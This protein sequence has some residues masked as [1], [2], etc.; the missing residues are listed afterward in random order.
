M[1]STWRRRPS[2]PRTGCV[3]TFTIREGA[4]YAS[5][6]PVLADHFIASW[7]R[8]LDPE[9]LSPMAAFMQPLKGFD[10]WLA[11][12][13]EAAL[14]FRAED[15]RNVVVELAA[16]STIF[17]SF[18]ASFVWAVID[19]AVVESVGDENFV[20]NGAGAGP[21]Q[22]TEYERDTRF[23]MEPNP[24]YYDA[25]SPSLARIVWPILNGP[26]AAREALDLY[27]N[28]EAARPTCRFRWRPRSRRTRRWPRNSCGWTSSQ[29]PSVRWPWTSGS[30]L[31]TTSACAAPSAGHRPGPLR[32]DLFRYVD[33]G[34][35]FY[36]P[37]GVRALRLSTAG[38]LSVRPRS[39]AGAARR[40]RL[41]EGQGLPEI[42]YYHPAGDTDEEL[43]R[44][45]AS[46]KCSK[47]IWGS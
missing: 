11:G 35:R 36:S 18:L 21:W 23:V 12:E 32:R 25:A 45:R 20:L 46:Y 47:K 7:T 15:D 34:H 43:Q 13:A 22:F 28:E 8:A 10:A 1:R 19:P 30:R 33:A 39:G 42:I 3:Y 16:P 41:P 5:G 9:N 26:D 4:T 6:D 37:G 2:V 27:R 14:G 24:N 40:S 31:S 44:V 17:P 38:W 29:A